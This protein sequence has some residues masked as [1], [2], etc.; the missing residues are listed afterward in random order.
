MV[1]GRLLVN[2]TPPHACA[3]PATTMGIAL[4]RVPRIAVL[5]HYAQT[6]DVWECVCGRLFVARPGWRFDGDFPVWVPLRR[7][8]RR[9]RRLLEAST[10][11]H[12]SR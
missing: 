12:D 7:Y 2:Q 5:D 9:A 10:Q 4:T 1:S 3:P 11:E 6:D 8:H